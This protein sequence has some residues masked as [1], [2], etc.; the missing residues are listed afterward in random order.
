[1]RGYLM[2]C[3][4]CDLVHEMEFNVLKVTGVKRGSYWDAEVMEP[5]KYRVSF[6]CRRHDEN[7]SRDS[8]NKE[9]R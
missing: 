5:D 1:M 6:R 7:A 9:D 3:C 4:D 8:A 2:Q